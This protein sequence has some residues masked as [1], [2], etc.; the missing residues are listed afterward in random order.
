MQV[1]LDHSAPARGDIT[2]ALI[3]VPALDQENKIGSLLVNF[4]GPG[5]PGVEGVLSV[6]TRFPLELREQFDIVGFDPRGVGQSTPIDCI[7]DFDHIVAEWTPDT[8]AELNLAIEEARQVRRGL[9]APKPHA[10][11]AGE[12]RGGR[13]RH[14]PHAGGSWATRS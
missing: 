8:P 13:A 4:G 1:P 14:G 9:P 2:M 12:Q 5:G 3:R 7:D 11:S 10:D 6:R